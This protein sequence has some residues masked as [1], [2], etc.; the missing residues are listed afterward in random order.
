M[1]TLQIPAKNSNH[2]SPVARARCP[3]CKRL[4]CRAAHH[5]RVRRADGHARHKRSEQAR[6]RRVAA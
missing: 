4:D 5:A 1:K 3:L 6:Q 2:N